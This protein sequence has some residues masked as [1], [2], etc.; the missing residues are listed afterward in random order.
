MGLI[1]FSLITANI[2]AFLVRRDVE[3]VERKEGA[4]GHQI[5]ELQA[6]IDR[7]EQFIER[8]QTREIDGQRV[9]RIR[10]RP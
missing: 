1:F 6:Q 2:A 10:K 4:L 8:L 9:A 3:K 7:I 5:K